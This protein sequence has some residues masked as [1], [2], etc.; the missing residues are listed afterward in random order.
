MT[1]GCC[2]LVVREAARL[3]QHEAQLSSEPGRTEQ[4]PA[5]AHSPPLPAT[6]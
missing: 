4:R 5:A 3:L 2:S 6:T 1:P